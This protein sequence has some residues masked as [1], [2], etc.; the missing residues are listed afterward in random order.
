MVVRLNLEENKSNILLREENDE[1]IISYYGGLYSINGISLVILKSLSNGL[2]LKEIVK[3]LLES[4]E[5]D[6]PQLIQDI[7]SF[8]KQLFAIG[9]ISKNLLE[10]YKEDLYEVS[11]SQKERFYRGK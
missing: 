7:E 11:E 4:Y 1:G 6:K 8:F 3:E 9:I 10:K 2:S 5:I